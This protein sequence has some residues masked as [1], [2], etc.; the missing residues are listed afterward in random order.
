MLYFPFFIR[1]TAWYVFLENVENFNSLS[2]ISRLEYAC[3]S[4]FCYRMILFTNILIFPISLADDDE[5]SEDPNT[6]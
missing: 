4:F 6:T 1:Q 3:I 5:G 2:M